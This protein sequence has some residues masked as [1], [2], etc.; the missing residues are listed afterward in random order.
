MN[1]SLMTRSNNTLIL[2]SP[3]PRHRNVYIRLMAGVYELKV[4]MGVQLVDFSRGFPK[5]KF[6]VDYTDVLPF[7]EFPELSSIHDGSGWDMDTVY[8]LINPASD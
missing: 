6:K 8:C 1:A 3:D 4:E 5:R 2:R 7:N